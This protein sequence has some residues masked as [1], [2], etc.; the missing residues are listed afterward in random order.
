[1][2]EPPWMPSGQGKGQVLWAVLLL[3]PSCFLLLTFPQ[4]RSLS[5]KSCVSQEFHSS[6]G[7]WSE[8]RYFSLLGRLIQKQVSCTSHCESA[9]PDER[10]QMPSPITL[11]TFTSNTR[12]HYLPTLK[13]L[14]LPLPFHIQNQL[15]TGITQQPSHSPD[16]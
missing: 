5:H 16:Q 10:F 12:L 2:P 13:I 4:P 11:E 14:L 15:Q 1:M 7:F 9:S 3:P 6:P 8:E